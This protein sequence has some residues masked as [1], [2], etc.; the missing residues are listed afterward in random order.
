MSLQQLCFYELIQNLLELVNKE[1]YFR[2]LSD[3][4]EC[5]VC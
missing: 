1:K 4:N 3:I 5:M 2:K